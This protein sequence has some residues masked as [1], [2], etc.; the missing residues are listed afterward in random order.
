MCAALGVAVRLPA[1]LPKRYASHFP[2]R[3]K[4]LAALLEKED[5]TPFTMRWE[6]KRADRGSRICIRSICTTSPICQNKTMGSD[7]ISTVGLSRR[8][9]A[10]PNLT[11]SP[12]PTTDLQGELKFISVVRFMQEESKDGKLQFTRTPVGMNFL[13]SCWRGG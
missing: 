5:H 12:L 7:P 10:S 4:P 3:A 1:R 6:T 9:F 13:S 11:S 8:A 2:L